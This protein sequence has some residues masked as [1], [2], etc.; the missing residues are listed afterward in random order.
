MK[1]RGDAGGNE[2]KEILREIIRIPN[3]FFYRWRRTRSRFDYWMYEIKVQRNPAQIIDILMHQED[4]IEH[5]CRE[6]YRL[7][8]GLSENK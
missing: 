7:R 4:L 6:A 2:M 1:E 3:L 5:Y 8:H